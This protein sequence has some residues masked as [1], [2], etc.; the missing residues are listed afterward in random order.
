MVEDP[1]ALV[2]KM[3]SLRGKL[4]VDYIGIGLLA[5]GLGTLQVV[6]DKGDREDW[7]SSHFIIILTVISVV[8]LL[9]VVF[10]ELRHK[11]PVVELR[12]LKERNF[13]LANIL[14]FVLGF[15]LLGSTV[16]LPLFLQTL[17]GYSATQA[18]LALSAGAV[19]MLPLLPL[20]GR[21][22]SKV[23][24]RWL[25]LVGFVT[26]AFAL[27]HLAT[28]NLN[29]NFATASMARIYQAIALAFLFVPINT[30]AYTA[31]PPGKSNNAS[32]L[33]NL[34]RNLGGSFGISIS[35]TLL[36]HRAQFHQSNLTSHITPYDSSYQTMIQG[37][38]QKLIE[39]GTGAVQAI[40]QANGVIYNLVLK[41]ANAL[42][43]L[44]IFW[45][46]G[47]MVVVSIPLVLMMKRNKIG[48]DAAM[49]H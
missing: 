26:M 39:Q 34:A 29:I 44:D 11:E 2:E 33:V 22:L 5:L 12:L 19:V 13:G 1:P 42:A 30:A 31:I 46:L 28:L 48:P 21:L 7:F 16:L 45:L 47:I 9:T 41:Q 23:E 40:A 27:F 18:G 20:V 8:S 6:L 36:A 17:M 10:W 38:T 43:F 14:M 24:A 25:I 35:T 4:N 32:A 49:A 3:K 37:L 15:L